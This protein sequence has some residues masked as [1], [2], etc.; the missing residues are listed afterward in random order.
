MRNVILL[1][2]LVLAGCQ[3]PAAS[4]AN[5]AADTAKDTWFR[6]V[7][8]SARDLSASSYEPAE[9]ITR[10]AMA[11]CKSEENTYIAY[12]QHLE[13]GGFRQMMRQAVGEQTLAIVVNRRAR[14]SAPQSA[15]AAPARLPRT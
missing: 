9:T 7:L 1:G 15:P 4:P 8:T 13:A 12:F 3:P 10:A 2:L 6:C 14:L 5:A 11:S